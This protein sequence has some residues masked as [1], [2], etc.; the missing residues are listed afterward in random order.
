[1]SKERSG[2][3]LCRSCER[4]LYDPG[5]RRHPRPHELRAF[6]EMMDSWRG[7]W[8]RVIDWVQDFNGR[9]PLANTG[10]VTHV[11]GLARTLTYW[12]G[13]GKRYRVAHDELL[14]RIETARSAGADVFFGDSDRH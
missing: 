4:V 8:W 10:E 11:D 3:V 7:E 12:C 13:C 9:K 2:R 5:A 6:A 14:A 1:M